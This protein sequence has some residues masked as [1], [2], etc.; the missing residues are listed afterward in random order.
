MALLNGISIKLRLLCL[1]ILP[2]IFASIYTVIELRLLFERVNQLSALQERMGML[3]TSSELSD[4]LH[5]LKIT[6]LNGGDATALKQKAETEIT[7]ISQFTDLA[8]DADTM[9]Q[10]QSVNEELP[11]L[12]EDYGDMAVEDMNDWSEWGMDLAVQRLVMLEKSVVDVRDANIEQQLSILYQLQWLKLWAQQENWYIHLMYAQPAWSEF[13]ES[14]DTVIERQQLTIER[15]LTINATPA[16]IEL[17]SNVFTDPAFAA[18][19][20]IRNAAFEGEIT[21]RDKAA[22]IITLDKRLSLIQFVV[23]EISQQLTTN[24]DASVQHAKQLIA[25]YLSAIVLST[26]LLMWLGT[27]LIRRIGAYLDRILRGMANLEHPESG[28]AKIKTDGNDEFTV[29]SHKLNQ[30]IEERVQNQKNL[31]QAKEEAEK[32]S[33]AKSSFLANMSHEIRTPLNGIIGMSGILSDTKLTPSQSEYVQTIETSSQT[34]LLLINDILDLSK[35][36]SGNLVLAPSECRV[37][38][39]AYDTIS[40]VLAKAAT[41][42]LALNVE[43]EHD[44][45]D[46]VL[47]DEYRLRQVLMNLA[48]NAVKFTESGSVTIAISRQAADEAGKVGLRFAVKDTGIGIAKDKQQQV[49]APFTQE[50]GSITREFGGTGLGLAICRQLV[51]LMGGEIALESEKGVGS[52]FFFTLTVEVLQQSADALADCRGKTVHVLAPDSHS[53]EIVERLRHESAFFGIEMRVSHAL[54]P[55]TEPV[56]AVIY[57]PMHDDDLVPALK[58]VHDLFP[59]VPLLLCSQHSTDLRSVDESVDGIISMP[60]LGLRF[61]KVV[62]NAFTQKRAQATTFETTAVVAEVAAEAVETIQHK[63]LI[64][65]DN[66][67]NQR[68]AG[69]FLT[70]AGYVCDFANNGKEAVDMIKTEKDYHAVLMDCMMPVMD[71]FTA[72]QNIREWEQGLGKAGVPIIALTASVLDEDISKCF[73]VGMDDYVAKPFKKNV[74]LGKLEKIAEPA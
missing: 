62:H 63:I 66:Q 10:M 41:S 19:F 7:A 24:I 6:K 67:V 59:N 32:A 72:T 9:A 21:S 55:A 8:L 3:A 22:D 35:I 23:E 39:V 2:L 12:I 31:V 18:S 54:C 1:V 43:L 74:L 68:V 46:V 49:F 29:F 45:P 33:I 60:L 20:Q 14:L 27:N 70:K 71:G 16:Q 28:D 58:Q 13:K 53:V 64:V 25:G 17:L 47:L 50:D 56:D 38:E 34:L 11:M 30:L 69:L 48:S 15:Y 57:C 4:A 40:I 5:G 26:L 73:D 51:E 36:E 42:G 65:E 37:R 44:V 61:A 52:T